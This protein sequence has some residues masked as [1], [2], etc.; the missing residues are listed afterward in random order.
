MLGSFPAY[1]EAVD[2][3]E[4]WARLEQ[5][6]NLLQ[7]AIE[8]PT[9]ER[10]ATLEKVRALWNSIDSARLPDQTTIAVDLRWLTSTLPDDTAGLQEQQSRVQAL[11]DYHKSPSGSMRDFTQSLSALDNVLKDP[12]FHYPDDAPT[13]EPEQRTPLSAPDAGP[14]ILAMAVAAVAVVL[15]YYFAQSLTVQRAAM[16]EEA[17]PDDD[18]VSSEAA[19]ELAARSEAELNYRAAIRYLYLSS[20]L[21]L[22]ERGLIRYDRSLT[23]REHLR[24]VAD[25][26]RLSD[27]LRPIVHVFDRVW[28]G[29][30]P[31]DAALYQDFTQNVEHLKQ[32]TP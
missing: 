31:V 26:P 12:R 29:F 20:L 8:Q 1:A 5:T 25:N 21:M 2:E 18:P 10:T 13:P 6:N 7:Q 27:L 28:Y 24:Q 15:L 32:L 30:A 9:N 17:D 22:D 23:N 3:R 4:F 16:D 11:L 14:F 19:R